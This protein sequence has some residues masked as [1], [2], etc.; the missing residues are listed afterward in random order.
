IE[1]I[2]ESVVDYME[3]YLEEILFENF[4]EE[5]FLAE[6]F[7]F[8]ENQM[9][10]FKKEED[11]WS[12]KYATGRWAIRHIAIMEEQ[13]AAETTIDE[14]CEKHLELND[15][16]KRSEERRV[17]KECRSQRGREDKR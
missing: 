3:E 1:H 16:R 9:R 12:S 4:K 11:S 17:G 6:K 8:T 5:A 13:N 2:N 10:K 15:V 7:V 14:F